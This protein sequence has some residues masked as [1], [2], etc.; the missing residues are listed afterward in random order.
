MHAPGTADENCIEVIGRWRWA[1]W[2]SSDCLEDLTRMEDKSAQFLGE[3]VSAAGGMVRPD[4]C[5]F[6][7]GR[8]VGD[9]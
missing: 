6:W 7:S 9:W 4:M 3:A 2:I 5:N 8:V 1:F